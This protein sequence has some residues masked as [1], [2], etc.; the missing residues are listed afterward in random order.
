VIRLL[1]K[2]GDEIA[3]TDLNGNPISL[4]DEEHGVIVETGE[5]IRGK[6]RRVIYPVV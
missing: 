6:T 2:Q 4:I 1:N 3:A 5:L